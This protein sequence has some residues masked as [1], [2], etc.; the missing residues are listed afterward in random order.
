MGKTT[1]AHV[2]ARHAGYRVVEVNASDDRSAEALTK[3][4]VDATQMQAVIGEKRPNCVVIDEIDGALGGAEGKGA[5]HALLKIVNATKK[6]APKS[7]ATRKKEAELEQD[8]QGEEDEDQ[9][10]KAAG[11]SRGSTLRKPPRGGSKPGGQHPVKIAGPLNRP[12]IAVCNDPY[13]PAL[14]PLRDAAKIFRVLPPASSRLNERLRAVCAKQ[15]MPADTRA[16]GALAERTE[17]DVRACLNALQMIF[18]QKAKDGA[19]RGVRMSDVVGER[20]VAGE[21]DMTTQ[22]RTVW[23]SLLSGHIANKRTRAQSRDGHNAHLRRLCASFGDDDLLVAGLFENVHSARMRDSSMIKSARALDALCDADAFH[24]R[25]FARGN[26]HLLP[27]VTSAAMTV[28]ACVSNA[29]A[30]TNLEWPQGGKIARAEKKTRETLRAWAQSA[31]PE[32][33]GGLPVAS[34]FQIADLVPSLLAATT[35]ELRPVAANFMKPHEAELMRDVVRTLA[36]F[37]LSF[38]PPPD[39]G[40]S[41]GGGFR[42]QRGM[43]TLVMDPPIDQATSFGA[44]VSGYVEP[45]TGGG[46]FGSFQSTNGASRNESAT[47]IHSNKSGSS[48]P[49]ASRRVLPLGVMQ[50]LAHEIRLEEIRAAERSA[51]GPNTPP[52]KQGRDE[53]QKGAEAT[54]RHKADAAKRLATAMGGLGGAQANAAKKSKKTAGN[55][56]GVAYKFNEGYTNAVRRTVFVRDLF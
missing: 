31:R 35:P 6:N 24:A 38:A 22:A 7:V 10:E 49:V 36:G 44:G 18:N 28:H 23:E 34:D 4:V 56:G 26:F 54:A 52:A 29:P 1:L 42:G 51:H 3:R 27:Y 37:R 50:M 13:A 55:Q 30:A 53:N 9:E 17:G 40:A 33:L 2:A 48:F 39:D 43:E 5:I 45:G 47:G 46:R 16:L 15:K 20:A 14:R 32:H 19:D 11:A 25:G 12:I 21:K 41:F 8:D